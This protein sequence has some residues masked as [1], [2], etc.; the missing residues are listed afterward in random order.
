METELYASLYNI[1]GVN[2]HINRI[3]GL[4]LI[5]NSECSVAWTNCTCKWF[6][7]HYDSLNVPITSFEFS[8]A[9]A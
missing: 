1:Y 4:T 9:F 7:F 6:S 8:K 2:D 3:I 5:Q